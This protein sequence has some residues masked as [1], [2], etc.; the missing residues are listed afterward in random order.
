VRGLAG[1]FGRRSGSLSQPALRRL[2]RAAQA[3]AERHHAAIRR[4]LLATDERMSDLLA[5]SG[6][7][8]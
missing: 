5:F 8:E 7:G 6:K 4:D 2:L 1:F 3:R